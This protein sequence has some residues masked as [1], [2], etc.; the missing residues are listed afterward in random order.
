MGVT[1]TV[2]AV[3]LRYVP[4]ETAWTAAT[5]P[6]IDIRS[7]CALPTRG[8]VEY[9][10]STIL[11]VVLSKYVVIFVMSFPQLYSQTNIHDFEHICVLLT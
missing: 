5:H 9:N 2:S 7:H 10:R 4:S 1:L 11:M 6:T 3:H 8:L